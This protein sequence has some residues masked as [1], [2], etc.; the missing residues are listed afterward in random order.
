ME[1]SYRT[2]WEPE[3]LAL[4]NEGHNRNAVSYQRIKRGIPAFQE[5]R[6]WKP[7]EIAL[8]VTMRDG[9]VAKKVKRDSFAVYSARLMRGIPSWK[10]RNLGIQDLIEGQET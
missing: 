4:L 8:L 5:Q 2:H 9:D 6:K 3:H 10:S 1:K 7:R